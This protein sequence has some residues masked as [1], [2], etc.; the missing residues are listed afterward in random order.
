MLPRITVKNAGPGSLEFLTALWH[1]TW[2]AGMRPEAHHTYRMRVLTSP[3]ARR[4]CQVLVLEENGAPR[5][6]MI[7]LTLSMRLRG[8]KRKVAGIAAVVTDPEHRGRG[9]AA[10]LVTIGH[11]RLADAGHQAA[12]LFTE[13]GTAYYAK[14]GYVTW[15]LANRT[16][17][18]PDTARTPDGLT[19]RAANERDVPAMRRLLN[20]SQKGFTLGISRPADYV[21]HLLNREIWREEMSGSK[22]PDMQFVT[23]RWIAERGGEP[24]A[25][26]RLVPRIGADTVEIAITEA[27]WA[28]GEERA[29]AALAVDY[30]KRG[31]Y[32]GIWATIP[33]SL[34]SAL[35]LAVTK[36]EPLEKMMMTPLTPG[37]DVSPA[38]HCIWP[39]DWF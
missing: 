27:G 3:W 16:L 21:R 39:G 34:A 17:A 29:V 1:R 35:G 10:R 12:L 6:G 26:A 13:I 7:V 18:L 8:K 33:E 2:Y 19:S 24:V 14:L 5:A 20:G 15:P 28:P 11:R 4:C 22:W 25:Y 31:N 32:D 37:L 38:E 36:V 30:A 23:A 9:L